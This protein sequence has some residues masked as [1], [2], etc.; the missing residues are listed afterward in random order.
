MGGH[1]DLKQPFV[2]HAAPSAP[3]YGSEYPAAAGPATGYPVILPGDQQPPP[4]PGA[5]FYPAIP[6]AAA[7]AGPSQPQLVAPPTEVVIVSCRHD[8][9][10]GGPPERMMCGN[11]RHLVTPSVRKAWGL[12]SCITA[13][14]LCSTGLGLCFWLPF[15]CPVTLDTVYQCPSCGA[16]L[17]RRRAPFE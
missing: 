7:A 14:G 4:P 16:E 10:C 17:Y 8:H 1:D 3:P 15:C 2:D 9:E 12:C 13:V 11:C 6:S 5:A